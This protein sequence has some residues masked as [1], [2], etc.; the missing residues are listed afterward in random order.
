MCLRGAA[1]TVLFLASLCGCSLPSN[2]WKQK[3]AAPTPAAGEVLTPTVREA[4]VIGDPARILPDLPPMPSAPRPA[5]AKPRVRKKGVGEIRPGVWGEYYTFDRDLP[6]FPP[7]SSETPP[8]LGRSDPRIAFEST[9]GAFAGTPFEDHFYVRWT[10]NLRAPRDGSYTFYL[11]SDDGSRFYLDGR[12]V[13]NNGGQHGMEERS[14]TVEL[15]AGNHEV[16]VEFFENCGAAGCKFSWQPPGGA[17]AIVGE[18]FLQHRA[19]ESPVEQF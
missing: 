4:Y 9:S 6:D 10:G 5:P 19:G 13:V 17:K 1:W 14:G 8:A 18:E 3:G 7:L 16:R 15:K 12:E 2:D 11:E